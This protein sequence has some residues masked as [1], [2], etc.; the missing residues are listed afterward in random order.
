MIKY[1]Y[2]YECLILSNVNVRLLMKDDNTIS[3]K[4][5]LQNDCKVYL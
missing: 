4:N 1:F 5:K 3:N 2:T